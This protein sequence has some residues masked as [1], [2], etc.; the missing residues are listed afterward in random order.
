MKVYNNNPEYGHEGPFA[1]EAVDAEAYAGNRDAAAAQAKAEARA[2]RGWK[3][4]SG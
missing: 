2:W 4:T 1:V 3:P